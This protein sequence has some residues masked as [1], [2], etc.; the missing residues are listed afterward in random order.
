MGESCVQN[1]SGERGAEHVEAV[2]RCL[3]TSLIRNS[4]LWA[5][6]YER[7]VPVGDSD[8]SCVQGASGERGAEH[9]EAACRYRGTLLARN[10]PLW[11]FSHKQ[12]VPVGDSNDESRSQGARTRSYRGTSIMRNRRPPQIT[13]PRRKRGARRG[14][15]RDRPLGGSRCQLFDIP[16]YRADFPRG[17][18]CLHC[19]HDRGCESSRIQGA[20]PA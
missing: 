11:A 2:R 15:R 17:G 1:A 7:G 9:V 4:P 14:A 20:C 3:G 16:I 13:R 19:L 8:S 10:S 18:R 12:G 6:S 5:F